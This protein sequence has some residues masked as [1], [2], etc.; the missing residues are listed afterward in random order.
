EVLVLEKAEGLGSKTSCTGIIGREC[1]SSF[2]VEEHVILRWANSARIFPP[3]GKSLRV[4]RDERQACIIDRPAFDRSMAEQAQGR[5]AQYRLGSPVRE[6][7]VGGSGVTVEVSSPG[8]GSTYNARVAV[9]AAGF[10]SRITEKLGLGTVG[11]FVMGAQAEVSTHDVDEVEVY[12]GRKIAPGFFAWL[13]PTTSGKAL[14]GL[15]SRRSPGIYLRKFIDTL[16]IK[17]KI[18]SIDSDLSHGGIPLK[19]LARTYGER[20]MVVGDAAGQVK[21]TTGGG[22][23]YGLLCAEIAANTLITALKAD[24]LSAKNL[25]RYERDWKNKLARELSVGYWSRK[26]YEHLTDR[27]VDRIFGIMKSSG[28]DRALLEAKELSFDWHSDI[29]LKLLGYRAVGKVV[30]VLKT[31]FPLKR[32]SK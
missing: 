31:P 26:L 16:Q 22:V 12:F 24:D 5:G 1:A 29:M 8:E 25:S 27:Q 6:V 7:K 9:V 21:P 15:L 19:P 11:D 2:P 13:V 30:D 23:Y 28:I 17:G 32:R 10:G 14:A 4:F 20:L 18:V 3:S